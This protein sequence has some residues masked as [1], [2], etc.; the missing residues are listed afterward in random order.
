MVTL[1]FDH[2][3]RLRLL[4]RQTTT[5]ASLT[6]LPGG[7]VTRA[8]G[9]GLE[10]ADLRAFTEGD[11][12][13]HIDRNATARSGKPQVRTFQAERDRTTLLV[14]D[15]RPSMLWGTR[16]TLR[17]IAAAE[18]LCLT[19][20]Q[21]VTDGG[22]VG[23]LAISAGAPRFVEP[24]A[25]DRAMVAVIGEM[26]RAHDAALELADAPDP[27][28]AD[29]LELTRRLARRRAE[30]VLATAF[31]TPGE[32]FTGAALQLE[33]RVSLSVIRIVD[34]FETSAPELR[35]RYCTVSGRS[36]VAAPRQL[37][38]S[39]FAQLSIANTYHAAFP[40]EMQV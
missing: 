35:Y 22:R 34:A 29:A 19:G 6:R 25:R 16:R 11:D 37:S 23:L 31:D 14:A 27:P 10:T 20:W 30:V 40:P 4:A 13:R 7:F 15:F 32:T 1:E 26:S 18:A 5:P 24:R 3:M 21:A 17:S 28:L 12:P 33:A 38:E 9:Q 36:G 2:L 8:R 39:N